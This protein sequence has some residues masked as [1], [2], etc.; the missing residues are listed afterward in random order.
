MV[1]KIRGWKPATFIF[2]NKS[3]WIFFCGR[4]WTPFSGPRIP[5]TVVRF[6]K[7]CSVLKCPSLNP[8]PSLSMRCQSFRISFIRYSSRV[9]KIL[10]IVPSNEVRSLLAVSAG[11]S[12]WRLPLNWQEARAADST[13][14]HCE[15][16]PL[17]ELF[18]RPGSISSISCNSRDRYDR[19]DWNSLE[20]CSLGRRP[21]SCRWS[22]CLDHAG[23][24]THRH[25]LLSSKLVV[26]EVGS[27]Y[28]SW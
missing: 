22:I 3:L 26:I 19:S 17:K 7:S 15:C 13:A 4:Y 27:K 10:I 2:D 1:Y 28:P 12:H 20:R 23:K 18:Y 14:L 25:G 11:I 16:R 5:M 6:L 9:P 24:E 8:N 21:F